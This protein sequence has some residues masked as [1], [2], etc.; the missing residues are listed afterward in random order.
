MLASISSFAGQTQHDKRSMHSS[1]IIKM[2][3]IKIKQKESIY[4]EPKDI[5]PRSL[6]PRS[7]HIPNIFMKKKSLKEIKP[8]EYVN[9]DTGKIRHYPPAAQE[10]F[11]SI[12]T[13]NKNIIKTLPVLD[14]NLMYLL[15]SYYNMG[16]SHKILN[17]KRKI[18]R[19]RRLSPRKVFV[20]KG[21]FKHTNSKV[22]ITLYL[23]NT[24]KMYL[25]RSIKKHFK[26]LFLARAPIMIGYSLDRDGKKITSHNRPY[27]LEEFLNSPSQSLIRKKRYPLR[28]KK[29]IFTYREVYLRS[30]SSSIK[31]ITS[32]LSIILKYYKYLTEIVVNKVINETEKL[33]IFS[34]KL[35]KLEFFKFPEFKDNINLAKWTYLKKVRRFF[36]LL[37]FNMVKSDPRFL[38]KLGSIVKNSYNKEVEF[39]IVELNQMYLNSDIY[40]Q[41]VALKLKN[42]K[43]SLY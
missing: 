31:R 23:Y 43:N 42:R 1:K 12:Y 40:T 35:P 13:Y 22:V 11:N 14:K 19:F 21:D 28:Y 8:L 20:G 17:I 16:I 26:L 29:K 32:S 2:K 3:E 10:W 25:I 30:I 7:S 39:N 37:R 4:I 5:A 38:R 9:N 18:N 41:A 34:F 24:E 33:R 15:K 27:T 36:Y 6:T